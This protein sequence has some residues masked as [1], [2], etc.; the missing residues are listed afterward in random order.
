MLI[1]GVIVLAPVFALVVGLAAFFPIM[2]RH[3]VR[4][5]N[6]FVHARLWHGR[7]LVPL[8]EHPG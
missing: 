8:H 4:D 7:G 6:A 1:V 5:R 3:A 2:Q